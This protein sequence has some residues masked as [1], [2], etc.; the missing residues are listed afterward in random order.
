[1]N[2][3]HR[4][5][6]RPGRIAYIGRVGEGTKPHVWCNEHGRYHEISEDD[7]RRLSSDP[8][9]MLELIEAEEATFLSERVDRW[10]NRFFWAIAFVGCAYLVA[11]VIVAVRGQ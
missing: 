7:A 8:G 10:V 5:H 1:M 3:L 11:Q 2:G 4:W 9:V 6:A